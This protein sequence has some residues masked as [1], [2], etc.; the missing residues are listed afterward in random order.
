MWGRV[1][2]CRCIWKLLVFKCCSDTDLCDP[3][4][5]SE[6]ELSSYR[7]QGAPFNTCE[8]DAHI[9]EAWAKIF[10]S[11][12]GVFDK[13]VSP[14]AHIAIHDTYGEEER[15]SSDL[16]GRVDEHALLDQSQLDQVLRQMEQLLPRPLYL[17]E[18]LKEAVARR[19]CDVKLESDQNVA[20][21]LKDLILSV[22]VV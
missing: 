12:G 7:L 19:R 2:S 1:Q 10:L 20:L 14:A 17:A 5:A 13:V 15:A 3:V 11:I 22:C 21:H 8:Q 9:S 6:A 18:A 4:V 16:R